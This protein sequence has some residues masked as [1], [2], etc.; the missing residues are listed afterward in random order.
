MRTLVYLAAAF[1]LVWSLSSC[2]PSTTI[3]ETMLDGTVRKTEIKGGIDPSVVPLTASAI[4]VYATIHPD[5]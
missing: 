1:A 5:K 3:T 4:R 2:A